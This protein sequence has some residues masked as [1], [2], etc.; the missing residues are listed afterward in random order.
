M[1][2]DKKTLNIAHKILEYVQRLQNDRSAPPIPE[3]FADDEAFL[4][5]HKKIIELRGVLTSLTRGDL[6]VPITEKGFISG[7]CKSLQA[8]LRHMAWK[9]RQIETE[10]YDQHI[11]FL[12]ELGASFNHMA[13]RLKQTTEALAQKE[14]ALVELASSLKDEV[15]KRSEVL[16]ELKKSEQRYKY[17]AQRDSLTGLL[18]RRFFFSSAIMGLESAFTLKKACCV[19]MLDVDNFKKFNDTYGHLEGDRALQYVTAHS[20]SALRQTDIMGRYGGEE[21]IFLLTNIDE[22]FA[23]AAVD[24][25]RQSIENNTFTLENGNPVSITAS[26]GASIILPGG[27]IDNLSEKLRVGIAHADTSLY[28]AKSQGKNQVCLSAEPIL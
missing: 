12:G 2:D 21:F 13:L 6:S 20:L 10:H 3:D 16:Q 24:R 4:N 15:K 7:L 27:D 26:I 14:Q 25:I 1:P 28:K 19:C 5:Y 17:L 18:N 23:Y 9:V 22:S 11:D 8:N